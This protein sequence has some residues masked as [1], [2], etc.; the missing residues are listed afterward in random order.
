MQVD[1]DFAARAAAVTKEIESAFAKVKHP[2]VKDMV[3]SPGFPDP[4]EIRRDFGNLHWRDLP[5]RTIFYH[6]EAFAW[7]TPA[8]YA[9]YLPAFMRASLSTEPG[10]GDICTYTIIAL[11]PRDW[12]DPRAVAKFEERYQ[13]LTEP[14]RNAVRSF[15]RVIGERWE[16]FTDDRA[17]D[18]RRSVWMRTA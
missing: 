18:K 17:F 2:G 14:Q 9:F 13:R 7:L 11:A 3:L 5:F 12:N 10:A 8:A 16:G 1:D 15:L 4:E 6:R